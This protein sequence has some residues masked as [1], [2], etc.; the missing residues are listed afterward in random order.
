[1]STVLWANYLDNGEVVSDRSDKYALYRFTDKLDDICDRIGVPRLSSLHDTTDMEFNLGDAALPDGMRSTDE[2]MAADG[3]WTDAAEA[4]QL[5]EKLLQSIR[6][7]Q[8]RFGIFRDARDEVIAELEESIE[9]VK[10]AEEKGALF[11][12]A[13]VM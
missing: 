1:M 10:E 5:L 12:F 6:D 2:L 3:L 9:L 4:R 11:N 8:P 7:E 13:V